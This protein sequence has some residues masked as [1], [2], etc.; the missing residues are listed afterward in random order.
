MM[1]TFLLD[2]IIN[3]IAEWQGME[4]GMSITTFFPPSQTVRGL[5]RI[6]VGDTHGQLVNVTGRE[7]TVS[8]LTVAT[9]SR[10][11]AWTSRCH[12]QHH[13]RHAQAH[14]RRDVSGRLG[15]TFEALSDFTKC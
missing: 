5:S 1:E 15:K 6:L 4:I 9:L 7:K 12:E 2:R 3:Q 11:P 14:L 13:A 10:S 8:L